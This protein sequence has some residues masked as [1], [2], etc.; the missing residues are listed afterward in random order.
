MDTLPLDRAKVND[1]RDEKAVTHDEDQVTEASSR[2][3]DATTAVRLSF[4]MTNDFMAGSVDAV[5]GE[6]Q[7]V[8]PLIYGFDRK[9]LVVSR[10]IEF[11]SHGR[12]FFPTWYKSSVENNVESWLFF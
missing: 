4:G 7:S 5:G 11:R 3:N 12:S 2:N 9:Q 1:G 10:V 6:N 8:V